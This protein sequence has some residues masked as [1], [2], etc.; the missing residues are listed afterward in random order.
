MASPAVV[1]QRGIA[2][3][4]IIIELGSAASALQ[5]KAQSCCPGLRDAPGEPPPLGGCAVIHQSVS[6]LQ[7]GAGYAGMKHV[8][9]IL[10]AWHLNQAEHT[11]KDE[12]KGPIVRRPSCAASWHSVP[13]PRRSVVHVS[14]CKL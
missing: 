7:G 3:S 8:L 6:Y 13:L 10:S 2:R 11:N 12:V 4:R 1:M 5:A 9:A 14:S